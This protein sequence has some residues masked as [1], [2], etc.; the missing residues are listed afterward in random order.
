[1]PAIRPPLST[2]EDIELFAVDD[3]SAQLVVR[4][5]AKAIIAEVDGRTIGAPTHAG[6]A[7]LQVDGLQPDRSYRIDLSNENGG[8]LGALDLRTRGKIG[9]V[10]TRFATISDVHLGLEEFGV[11]RRFRDDHEVPYALRCA[12]A[13][14]DDATDWGAEALI[15][16]G[17][18]TESGS[19]QEWEL[20]ASLFDG[21]EVPVLFTPG[22]HDVWKTSDTRPA[23]GARSIGLDFSPVQLLDLPGVRVVLA[24]TSRPGRGSGELSRVSR[25]L[26]DAVDQSAPA[27]VAFHHNIQR[28]R[29]PWFWPPGI[30]W[31]DARPTLRALEEANRQL[32]LTSG[33]THRNR[34]HRLGST[35]RMPYTE[36]SST[37]DYPGVWAGYEVSATH[38]RQTVRRIAPPD[39]VEW[40]ERTRRVLG[41]IWPRW[42]QGRLDD[43]CVDLDLG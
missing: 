41:G 11:M 32:F 7:V 14:I 27:V 12:R 1:M 29:L 2:L 21:V 24:D 5:E 23:D 31:A 40:T 10:L 42:S 26:I 13:A 20:A 4:S 43:R 30:S 22:N 36:V 34:R 16:K 39:V 18:L 3:T 6:V 9:P 35:G 8:P 37:S 33:H 19:A 15:V 25:A 38:I 17:D 28:T